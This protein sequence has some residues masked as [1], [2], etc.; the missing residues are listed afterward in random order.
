MEYINRKFKKKSAVAVRKLNIKEL[1]DYRK[2]ER[3]HFL[4]NHLSN[5]YFWS[6]ELLHPF[7]FMALGF[8]HR[9]KNIQI[10]VKGKIPQINGPV[11]FSITHI[12]MYDVEICLQVIRKHVYMLSADEEAMY[13]TF[14]GS[15]FNANGVIYVDPEDK[16]DR[17]IALQTA[18]KF[19]KKRKSL[20]WMPEGIWNLSPNYVVLPMHYG[21]IEAAAA[22]H[23]LIVPI[24]IEQYDRADGI[25][26]I[27][28]IGRVFEP[29]KYIDGELTKEKK[30]ELCEKLRSQMASL[31]IET[32]E[33][34]SRASIE[35]NYYDQFIGKRIREWPYYTMDK[36]HQREFNPNK[37][38]KSEEVF[39][40]LNKIEIS[41]HNAFLARA[42]YEYNLRRKG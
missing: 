22:A 38:I 34:R 21:I 20:L 10:Y 6:R 23:A 36:I 39:A 42:W 5:M 13:R 16:E 2:S 19:L 4:Y 37:L 9:I 26:F 18:I 30:I 40:F 11:I 35:S 8:Y 31:K 33:H 3:R 17:K 29:S 12:G 25:H 24:G 27:V 41:K 7:L 28:N 14:D 1:V 15:F 32:W